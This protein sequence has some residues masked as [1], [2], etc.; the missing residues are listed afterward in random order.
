[1]DE[2]DCA[3]CGIRVVLIVEKHHPENLYC[4]RCRFIESLEGEAKE[5]AAKF[6]AK[7]DLE[8]GK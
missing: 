1:M 7:Q 4:L 8:A 2:Y 6:F 3:R 5:E